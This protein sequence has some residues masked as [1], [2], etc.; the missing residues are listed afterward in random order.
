[1]TIEIPRWLED[2]TK[3]DIIEIDRALGQIETSL[4]GS[5]ANAR[6]MARNIGMIRRAVRNLGKDLGYLMEFSRGVVLHRRGGL[7]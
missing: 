3:A 5:D 4:R 1:M 7:R 6:S 2:Q